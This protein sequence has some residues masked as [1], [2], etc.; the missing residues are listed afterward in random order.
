[1]YRA[2][3]GQGD[4]I[5]V[6][7]EATEMHVVV[8]FD[9]AMPPALVYLKGGSYAFAVPFQQRRLAYP[10]HSFSGAVHRIAVRAA[11]DHEITARRNLAFNPYDDHGNKTLFPHGRA[12]VETRG[13]T[14]FAARNAI[15]GE[16]ATDGHGVWPHTSWGINRDPEATLTIEFGRPVRID[17]AVFYLRADFPHDAWWERASLTLSY[18]DT[19]TVPFS[20]SGTAQSF[21]L[22]G[23]ATEWVRLHSLMKADDPS[24][25]PALTQIEFWGTE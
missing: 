19:I 6:E 18:G 1:M 16:K 14:V 9:A 11:R 2:E 17:E 8:W 20:K 10:P 3:Y 5:V 23:R 12:N 25:F 15:D 7:G 4:S 21:A 22:E 24:P 13:E